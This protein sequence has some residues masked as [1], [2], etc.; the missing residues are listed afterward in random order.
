M[1]DEKIYQSMANVYKK[2]EAIQKD[3]RNEK[4]GFKFRG[5]D[6][7]Y[8][9][10]HKIFA[11]EEIFIIPERIDIKREDV[12]SSSG[13]KGFGTVV[14]I[15]FTFYTVDGSSVSAI[16][17]GESIDYG[18]KSTSKAQSMAIKYALL[19]V[20]MIPTEDMIDSDKFTVDDMVLNK[21]KEY[22][23][24]LDNIKTATT[25]EEL[26]TAFSDMVRQFGTDKSKTAE[27]TQVKDAKKLELGL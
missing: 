18:D 7:V 17:D 6:D 10:L 24:L 4:Q 21:E 26:K 2:V 14:T 22:T 25:A 12:V 27:I 15:K 3:K 20:F 8:N 13:T 16:V 19:Q 9:S 23:R 1:C 11:E 5:I